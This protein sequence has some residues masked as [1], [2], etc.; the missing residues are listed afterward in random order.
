[1]DFGMPRPAGPVQF[2]R[3]DINGLDD[4]DGDGDIDII[5]FNGF[6]YSPHFYEN[7]T[8]NPQHIPYNRD[9]LVF[10]YRDDCWGYIQYDVNSG[11]NRFKLQQSKDSLGACTYQL[12]PKQQMKHAGSA[13]LL[14]DLNG[15][16][17]K[18]F[19]YGD[20]S[21]TSLISLIDGRKQNSLH[22]DSLM[23]QDTVF[24]KNTMA[25]NF[26]IQ[27]AA[28]YVDINND[29]INELLVTT[30]NTNS[31]KS[32]NNVWVYTNSGTNSSPVFQYAGNNFL[33]YTET[34]DLGTR[35]VP[36]LIDI[37][38]DGKKDLVVATNGDYAKN[39]N[40]NDRLVLYKNISADVN[41][42]IYYL[43]DTNF[44]M[45]SKD[46]PILN[47]HPAF[48]D[49]NGDGKEDLVIGDANGYLT[50]YINNSVGTTY[51]FQLQSRKYA[52]IVAKGGYAAP[53]LVDLNKDGKLDLVIGNKS[54]TI[55]YFQNTG[56][57]IVP[58]FSATPTIDSLGGL[59]VN[60][61]T[62]LAEGY[63]DTSVTGYAVPFVCDLDND[64]VYEM[65]AGCESGYLYLYTNVSA[66]PGA[67]FS[68]KVL[69]FL[70]DGYHF[71]DE[72]SSQYT[73]RLNFGERTAPFAGNIDGDA[74]PDIIMG[75]MRG[76]LNLFSSIKRDNL[77][78]GNISGEPARNIVLYPNPA[79]QFIT[80]NTENID[81]NLNYVV[82][83]EVGKMLDKGVVS[84]YYSAKTI[85]TDTYKPGIYF[86]VF[87]GEKGY[88]VAR[89]FLIAR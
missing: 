7:W 35:S 86:I 48:G 5:G 47:L 16:G 40:Y 13:T 39:F 49:L 67:R 68:R 65:L 30:N 32:V 56:S 27:P 77:G 29:S 38:K 45:L 20:V 34:V 8:I 87:R 75:N 36:V 44:L 84:K 51:S 58:Q 33:F 62:K 82:Y 50:Y 85:A 41:K 54:G 24:P 66:A 46:T 70:T 64:G 23:N 43:A 37:D 76:G 18:D 28:Y 11:K 88:S 19:V 71:I 63:A 80:I 55:Q 3:N 89:R 60:R 6:D 72:S 10:I 2:S 57:A 81:E 31:A 52:N 22:R 26:I 69:L 17:I 74:K 14:V 79:Q 78:V 12:Y 61:I 15:D 4:L 83:D 42:P 59:Y 25:A 9:S 21:F 53:Q 73:Y 1:V